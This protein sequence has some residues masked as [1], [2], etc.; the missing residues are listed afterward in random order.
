V[1]DIS[2]EQFAPACVFNQT[3]LLLHAAA[4]RSMH[5]HHGMTLAFYSF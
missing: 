5:T 4:T 1:A 3:N 2:I